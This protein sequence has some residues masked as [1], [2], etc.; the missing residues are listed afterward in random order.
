MDLSEATE[1]ASRVIQALLGGRATWPPR[2]V[3]ERYSAPTYRVHLSGSPVT[4]VSSVSTEG[5]VSLD[6]C[7]ELEASQ[8]LVIDEE[9]ALSAGVDL[10][11]EYL[12]VEYTY[13]DEEPPAV[14]A[15]AVDVLAAEL[16]AASTGEYCRLPER[17]TSVSRQGV[18]YTVLDPQ[19]FLTEGRTG[20]YEIDL[21]LS[22]YN[23][24]RA[25]AR[26]RVFS[27]EFPPGRRVGG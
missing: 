20:I 16:V 19:D 4:Y 15:H 25:K 9:Q 18:S 2:T 10:S 26:A 27:P 14:I 5:G 22:V 3:L 24:G 6:E 1:Y 23:P 12:E 11:T 21:A 7:T 13:G 8:F 17:V